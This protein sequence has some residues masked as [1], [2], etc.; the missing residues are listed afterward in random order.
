MSVYRFTTDRGQPME[1]SH[2]PMDIKRRLST[3][4][5]N[6]LRDWIY[7][8]IDGAVTTFAI[9]SGV[10]GGQLSSL[11]ILILGFA[12]LLADGFSM[13]ASNYLGTKA[14]RERYQQD[15]AIE[16]KHLRLVPEGEKAEIRAMF[17]DQG[18]QGEALERVVEA[19]T[20]NQGLWLKTMLQEEYG[21]P[22]VV[23]SP[24]KSAAWTFISF[25]IFGAIPLLPYVFNRPSAFFYSCLFT[26]CTFFIIGAIKSH[27]SPK[28]WHYSGL[29]TLTLGAVTAAL[30]YVIGWAL[31]HYLA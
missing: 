30:A 19:I 4:P 5:Q 21:L 26:G 24:L 28:S 6:Y 11:V 16:E 10:V 2:S 13:A 14:E 12:N 23:P 15:K 27:W 3:N 25:L 9:V 29:E 17:A 1:H 31:H 8:G 18:L 7:G 20:S 22:K